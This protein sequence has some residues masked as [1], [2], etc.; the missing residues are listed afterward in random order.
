MASRSV[1]T[2]HNCDDKISKSFDDKEENVVCYESH[3]N[4]IVLLMN[5]RRVY[6]IELIGSK[7]PTESPDDRCHNDDTSNAAA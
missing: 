3:Q 4:S 5:V 6:S 7:F 1:I 2:Q